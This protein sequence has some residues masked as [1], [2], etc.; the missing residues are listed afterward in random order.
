[1]SVISKISNSARLGVTPDAPA[2]YSPQRAL[3]EARY[4]PQKLHV[5]IYV[6]L[7]VVY[8]SLI[9]LLPYLP[10]QDGVTH[11]YNVVI[12]R[13][14][15]HHQGHWDAFY[16]PHLDL[17]P[18]PNLAFHAIVY[19]LLSFVTPLAA[20]RVFC[21]LY[22]LLTCVS[23]PMIL[24]AFG[25]SIFPLA[26]FA[27]IAIF[28][29]L[30]LLG[31]YNNVLGVPLAV[32]G[33]AILWRVRRRSLPVRA[34][35]L[36]GFG[37]ALF[38][39]HLVPFAVFVLAAGLMTLTKSTEWPVR[40]RRVAKFL[41]IV[42]PLLL[43]GALYVSFQTH[44]LGLG[45][46]TMTGPVKAVG[47][48]RYLPAAPAA[49]HHRH[50]IGAY[51]GLLDLA[52]L[53]G[54]SF[55]LWHTLP[56][57]AAMVL[58]LIGL[59]QR[60]DEQL[61][62]NVEDYAWGSKVLGSLCV[63]LVFLSLVAP[64]WILGSGDFKLRLPVLVLLFSLPLLNPNGR[65]LSARSYGVLIVVIAIVAWFLNGA[66]LWRESK[67]V[68]QFV[69]GLQAPIP[70]GSTVLMADFDLKA[71]LG[72][73]RFVPDSLIH[74]SAYYGLNGD[75]DLNNFEANLSYFLTRELHPAPADLVTK[76]FLD[77]RQV[78][79]EKI[80]EAQ[81]LLCWKMPADQSTV[82]SRQFSLFW[83]DDR[84]PLTIWKRR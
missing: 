5:F 82:L 6:A 70:P 54:L 4:R 81:Y 58:V 29:R 65:L 57:L 68:E 55:S 8:L 79:W 77:P 75:V 15:L 46:D 20:Q 18:L 13:D 83:K 43:L 66:T 38:H 11:V 39:V 35:V 30:F 37:I 32:F 80:P 9:W 14:L 73:F 3:V 23:V 41:A 19:P 63:T 17:R 24:S 76:A 72:G 34:A 45:L 74:A 21:S 27:F 51:P 48:S 40:I 1:M 78:D 62:M 22:V 50:L 42:S 44:Y 56:G 60:H 2:V 36:N 69:L 16:A 25:R 53:S 33:V 10:T 28:N 49:A 26:Y 61:P 7:V 84:T 52:S 67:K 31:F 12:L 59:E 71:T 47:S 64:S